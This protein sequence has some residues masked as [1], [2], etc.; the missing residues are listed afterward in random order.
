MF[1][2]VLTAAT[3]ALAYLNAR[4]GHG[5]LL[6][7]TALAGF[8]DVHAAAGSA[9][10]LLAGG[11]AAPRDAMLAVLLAVTT[12]MISKAAGALAG[13]MRYALDVNA[14][15]SLVLLACWLPFWLLAA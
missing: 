6:G 8:F 10:S 4:L 3:T 12:N 9:L 7:G 13:G 2:V 14:S 11:A 5:A 15:L 1:A